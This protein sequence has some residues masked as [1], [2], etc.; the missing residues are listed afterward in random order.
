[1]WVLTVFRETCSSLAISGVDRQLAGTAPAVHPTV[2]DREYSLVVDPRESLL[3]V[4]RERLD[5][6][7]RRTAATRALAAHAPCTFSH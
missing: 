3:D 4:P 6:K 5:L 7:A 1:M 2:N